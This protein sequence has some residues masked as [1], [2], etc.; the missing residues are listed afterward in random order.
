MTLTSDLWPSNNNNTNT[1]NINDNNIKGLKTKKNN[2]KY[3]IR[4]VA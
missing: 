2:N 4:G 1:N 3:V